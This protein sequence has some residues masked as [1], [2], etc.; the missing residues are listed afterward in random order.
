M[1]IIITI[2]L[3]FLVPMSPIAKEAFGVIV[4]ADIEC[5]VFDLLDSKAKIYAIG[6][7][8]GVKWSITCDWIGGAPKNICF[9]HP[10]IIM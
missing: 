10:K 1:K 9:I 6:E 3:L 5:G 2:L 7:R 8:N 4:G